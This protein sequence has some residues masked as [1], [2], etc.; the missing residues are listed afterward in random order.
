MI[1]EGLLTIALL[2]SGVMVKV[3]K[4]VSSPR[5]AEMRHGWASGLA[6]PDDNSLVHINTQ[7]GKVLSPYLPFAP[8]DWVAF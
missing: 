6:E 1:L 5:G 2:F 7:S 8:Y 3:H 4:T